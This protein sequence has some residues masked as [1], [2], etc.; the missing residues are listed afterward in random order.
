MLEAVLPNLRK[1][2]SEVTQQNE[3]G[4]LPLFGG[5]WDFLLETMSVCWSRSVY[6]TA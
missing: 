2:D 1:L 5:S 3:L 6:K 4:A